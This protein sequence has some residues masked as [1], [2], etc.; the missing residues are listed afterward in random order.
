MT[1]P[2]T[3]TYEP[4]FVTPPGETLLELLEERHM[5]QS[6]LAQR[7]GRPLKT[8][9]E[10]IRGKTQLTPETALQLELVFGTP[11]R[12]W[13]N[14]EQNYR[15]HLARQAADE[16]LQAYQT[17]L[18]RFPIKDMQTKG[19][20]PNGRDRAKLLVDL[21]QF[22]G[23]AT[24]D[25]WEDIWAGCL[26]SY[27]KTA[28][29]ESN[30]HALSVWLRQGELEA[31]DIHCAPY[32]E[33]AFKRL[34]FHNIRTLTCA[35]PET[36]VP[37]LV[38]LCAG[39]GVAV[40]LVPQ[41]EGARVSG[42]TRWLAKDKALIQLS[43]RY[44]TNDHFWFTFFHEAGHIIL[45]GKRDVF[46]NVEDADGDAK[47]QEANQ[48]AANTLI[49]PTA[50]GAFVQKTQRFSETAV[51]QFATEMGIAPGIVVG[52]LQHDAHL[53]YKH[54]NG[55]KEKFVWAE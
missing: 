47:E 54:L 24:P 21:L 12:V 26:V 17:W 22:F 36:F 32:D 16:S 14:L 10:I 1:E 38:N 50:Y 40:T 6:E 52:R 55:L 15:E 37:Q 20:L 42:A 27:R 18:D 4:D 31:Q 28:A 7:M 43:L 9:N 46:I 33:A 29:Y 11:A 30:D 3:Y 51:R 13:L 39:A 35:T 8:I 34:L 5:T 48:F 44:K 23:L 53:P 2:I 49:P 45:H 25:S 41:I 19:W